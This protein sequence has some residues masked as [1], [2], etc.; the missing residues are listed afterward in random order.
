[1]VTITSS[2]YGI[3]N[4]VLTAATGKANSTSSG[5]AGM[6]ETSQTTAK[7]SS[8]GASMFDALSGSSSSSGMSNIFDLLG[9]G[10]ANS[11]IATILQQQK[12][13]TQTNKIFTSVAQRLD[14][15]QAGT[16]QP[17]A[18][19][20]K[21]A[22]YGMQT[23]QPI[24]V[25]LDK[26]GQIQV[27]L[28]SQS[29]LSKFSAGQQ[30]VIDSTLKDIATLSAKITANKTNQGLIK[31]L[32]GAETDLNAVFSG[33]LAPQASTP[34]NWEQQGVQLMQ[35]NKP[36][37][38][39]LD[40]QG[41]LQVLD[42][43]TNVDSNLPID[44]QVILRTAAQSV[45]NVLSPDGLITAEWQSAAAAFA[46]NGVPFHL[47][48]DPYNL[49][50]GPKTDS[51]GWPVDASGQR[52]SVSGQPVVYK[53]GVPGIK[54]VEN[55]ADNITPDFL[56]DDPYPD[57]G[58]NT[59]VLKQAAA[60]IQKGQAFLLDFDKGGHVTAKAATAQNIIQYNAPAGSTL[61][62]GSGSVLSVKA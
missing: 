18:D 11:S 17:S 61:S 62:L 1:M 4:L 16:I 24:A 10:G 30:K 38:I 50:F 41:N 59:P 25:S 23:G 36:F 31:K 21:V 56:K 22:A 8:S 60:L 44:Q 13:T 32:A 55:S 14:A 45:P 37:T 5:V 28:Q 42:Q 53:N 40:G 57:I 34:N 35:L 9:S 48:V 26:K 29:D 49:D 19:W 43:A 39:S 3:G 7:A 12:V 58:A 47:E 33:A 27:T 54:V 6:L 46:Q 51:Y 2:G 52:S 20:E 15:I